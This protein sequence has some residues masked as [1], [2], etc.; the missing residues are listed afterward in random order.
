MRLGSTLLYLRLS[1]KFNIFFV[2]TNS[3]FFGE[4][5]SRNAELLVETK[6]IDIIIL[7]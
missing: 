5:A 1:H 2:F 4:L 3:S 7:C 6:N